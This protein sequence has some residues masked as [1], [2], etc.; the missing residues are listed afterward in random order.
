MSTKA[1]RF[2]P[3]ILFKSY[4]ADSKLFSLHFLRG[5]VIALST[6]ATHR[7][8]GSSVGHGDPSYAIQHTS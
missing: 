3:A 8:A 6:A 5:R 1:G 2:W 4:E 7:S